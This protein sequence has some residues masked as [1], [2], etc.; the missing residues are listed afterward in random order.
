MVATGST[1]SLRVLVADDFPDSAESMARYLAFAGHETQIA[2]DGE[3]AW[4]R[5]ITWQPHACVLDLAMPKLD[6]FDLARRIRAQLAVEQP[7]LIAL[8]GWVDPQSERTA[9]HAG[10]DYYFKK[11]IE[12]QQLVLLIA[13]QRASS[14]KSR[15]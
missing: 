9:Y 5:V 6:G 12:P 4:A 14:A 3:E 15:S 11:P 13:Q 1:A 7:L 8:T 2:Q 10:F